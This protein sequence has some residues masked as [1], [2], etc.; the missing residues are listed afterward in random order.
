MKK[1]NI[2]WIVGAVF[3]ALAA[4]WNVIPGLTSVMSQNVACGI[5]LILFGVISF[6]AAFT[7]GV[8]VSGSGWLI[9]EGVCSVL[10]G[11]SFVVPSFSVSFF[12]VSISVVLGVWLIILSLSQLSRAGRM[13][14]GAGR[15]INIIT[16][17]FALLGGLS[18]FVAPLSNMY[19]ISQTI[20]ICDY[21]ISYLLFIAAILVI[22]RCFAKGRKS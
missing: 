16:G 17:V 15:V 6:L 18:V 20:K 21:N 19:F 8:K 11:I 7:A 3:L 1:I 2:F 5:S 4:L 14:R 9:F 13:T 12:T 10:L 22:S